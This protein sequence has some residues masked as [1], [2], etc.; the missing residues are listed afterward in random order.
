MKRSDAQVI[1]AQAQE[2]LKKQGKDPWNISLLSKLTGISRPTLRKYKTEGFIHTHGNK[3]RIRPSKLQGF[4]KLIDELLS[5]GVSNS[6]VVF[7]LF[8]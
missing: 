7:S 8:P 3:G 5:K 1:V 4:Q 6:E 2:E